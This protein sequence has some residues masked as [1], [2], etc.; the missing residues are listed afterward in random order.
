MSFN[1][2]AN[3]GNGVDLV[4]ELHCFDGCNSNVPLQMQVRREIDISAF[5]F[6]FCL[7]PGSHAGHCLSGIVTRFTTTYVETIFLHKLNVSLS[8][9]IYSSFLD[10]QLMFPAE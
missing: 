3:S 9:N 10:S 5:P 6:I 7:R 2:P 4:I 8:S 1:F